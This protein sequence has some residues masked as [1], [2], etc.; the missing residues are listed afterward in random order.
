MK[1]TLQNLKNIN[2][3]YMSTIYAIVGFINIYKYELR[4]EEFQLAFFQGRKLDK[5]SYPEVQEISSKLLDKK[6][7]SI[8]TIVKAQPTV[9]HV[10]PDI[11]IL[12]TEET[13]VIGEV[14]QKFAQNESFWMESFQ[15]L[16]KYDDDLVG[17][18]VA[19][20]KVKTHDIVLLVHESRSRPVKDFFLKHKETE[21]KFNRPFVIIEYGRSDQADH[22]FKFRIEEGQLSNRKIHN[23][24]Y[25][26]VQI[27]MSLLV[28][29]YSKIKIY[30]APPHIS[31]ML[32]II[33]LAMIDKATE[34]G[35]YVK[36]GKKT[37]LPISTSLH[38]I[39]A[40]LQENYSFKDIHAHNP[41]RQSNSP[42][43][44]WVSNAIEKLIT[45]GEV[46][47]INSGE[48]KLMYYLKRHEGDSAK[49]YYEKIT[50]DSDVTQLNMFSPD[51]N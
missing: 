22:F 39:T 23:K 50:L 37:K 43:K 42:Q 5:L 15:Q 30:D 49:E 51:V 38:E 46:E 18:P 3:D 44:G 45:V 10:T 8:D 31:W 25:K 17:W 19:S 33:H 29:T 13:G 41:Q 24:I 2:D 4:N 20:E 34:M 40:V 9:T 27:K 28:A 26:Q 12:D 32:Y 14:K 35:T 21:L 1:P 11:G 16:K 36:L 7:K 6:E 48:G 47:W